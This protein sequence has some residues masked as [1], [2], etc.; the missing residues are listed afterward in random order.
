MDRKHLARPPL[1]VH[2]VS[3]RAMPLSGHLGANTCRATDRIAAAH[4]AGTGAMR[5]RKNCG[6]AV[7]VKI[8]GA[9]GCQLL[10][11]VDFSIVT[12]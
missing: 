3:D 7:A 4:G 2:A 1:A 11:S 5:T 8:P 6:V 10:R 12:E 9:A